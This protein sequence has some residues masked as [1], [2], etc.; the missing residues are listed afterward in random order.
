VNNDN[1]SQ[2]D[3]RDKIISVAR[4]EFARYGLAGSRVDR[5]ATNAGV[6]KAMIYYH[7]HSKANLYQAIIEEH[8]T[9]IFDFLESQV[10]LKGDSEIVL[11]NISSFMHK[12]LSER[13]SM[14]K[15]M[16]REIADG[17]DRIRAYFA[18]KSG[19][20]GITQKFTELVDEQIGNG[21]FRNM[22]SRQALISFLG[23][24]LFYLLL[25][26]LVNAVWEITDENEFREHRPKE[27]VDLFLHGIEAGEK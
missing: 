12:V 5:I 19:Q 11:E 2:I 9:L 6:N 4:E 7:F 25:K 3:T 1:K 8:V 18:A 14:I 10:N 22:D 16:L 26:P 20:K 17:G 23:M 21:T 27:I 24:N 13:E 15:L